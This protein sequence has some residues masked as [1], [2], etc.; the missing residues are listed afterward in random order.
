MQRS[1]SLFVVALAIAGSVVLSG[2]GSSGPDTQVETER[3]DNAKQMRSIFDSAGGDYD[4]L[5]PEDKTKFVKI[6]G[7]DEAKA[8]HSW[9]AMKN[10]PSMPAGAAAGQ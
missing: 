6:F 3:V 10:G 4:K 2:C 7:G 1:F 8:K 5:S 9:D